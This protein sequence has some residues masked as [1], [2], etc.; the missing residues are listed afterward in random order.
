MVNL[1]RINEAKQGN[2]VSAPSDTP[3]STDPEIVRQ[4]ELETAREHAALYEKHFRN[5]SCQ[6]SHTKAA[7]ECLEE[8]LDA[9]QAD[10]V[11]QLSKAAAT[12]KSLSSTIE[13]LR[14]T[15]DSQSD[16]IS[17]AQQHLKGSD[18]RISDLMK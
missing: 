7:K 10:A 3:M 4:A 8:C 15:I 11:A 18:S 13:S 16:S 2:A 1:A 17:D 14:D 9:V 5:A 12:N 6:V